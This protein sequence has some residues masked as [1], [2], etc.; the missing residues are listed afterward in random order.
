LLAVPAL[1][2]LGWIVHPSDREND[3][4]FPATPHEVNQR[5]FAY[6][7][8]LRST[9]R[10]VRERRGLDVAAARSAAEQWHEMAARR[11][12]K[13]LLPPQYD[14]TMA[15]DIRSQVQ[16][17]QKTLVRKLERHGVEA[18]ASG[19]AKTA[20]ED[21]LLALRT[22]RVLK[23][24]DWMTLTMTGIEERR[25]MDR[26]GTLADRLSSEDRRRFAGAVRG[27]GPDFHQ[28][29]ELGEWMKSLYLKRSGSADQAS[30]TFGK[31]QVLRDLAT[32]TDANAVTARAR[33]LRGGRRVTKDVI[34]HAVRSELST[35]KTMQATVEKLEG[36]RA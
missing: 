4:E 18:M 17:T 7:D 33:E 32:L 27:M 20:A 21:T 5:I 35:L 36:P 25:M 14:A 13:A 3:Y 31:I 30:N 22:I 19:D 34:T 24:S 2:S 10:A 15:D 12:L 28:L 23:Y 29:Q 8:V 16:R 9:E 26:L 11:E 1:L 6:V